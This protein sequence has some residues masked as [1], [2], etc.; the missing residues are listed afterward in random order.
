VYAVQL[1]GR[2]YAVR[3]WLSEV[4][5]ARQRYTSLGQHLASGLVSSFVGFE[6]LDAAL[7]VDGTSFPV[8]W[9]EWASGVPL[10]QYVEQNLHDG[11][12]LIA[13]SDAF[14][15]AVNELHGQEVAHGDLQDENILVDTANPGRPRVF[16]IDYDSVFVPALRS[17]PSPIL[18]I[19]NYQHPRRKAVGDLGETADHFSELVIYLSLRALA[20]APGLWTPGME[21]QLLLSEADFLEPDGSAMLQRLGAVSPEVRELAS[22]LAGFCREPDPRCLPPLEEVLGAAR[23]AGVGNGAPSPAKPPVELD[24]KWGDFIPRFGGEGARTA[25]QA[26]PQPLP[27]S[28]TRPPAP[29]FQFT[30]PTVVPGKSPAPVRRSQMPQGAPAPPPAST[31]KASSAAA[32]F[33]TI[34]LVIL[35]L[36]FLT[37]MLAA[38]QPADA[39]APTSR[40]AGGAETDGLPRPPHT[41]GDDTWRI[42]RRSASARPA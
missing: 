8:L 14:R 11:T 28:A 3:C 26:V 40:A 41:H 42:P 25:A 22:T 31:R 38:A 12:A 19:P 37:G 33:I 9:M 24:P 10:R 4:T 39:P 29:P 15:E 27:P 30:I 32:V 17:L 21:K 18:G 5:E 6:Y 16:L 20:R 36:L 13:L 7:V 1:N 2:R 34:V 35:A 23:H